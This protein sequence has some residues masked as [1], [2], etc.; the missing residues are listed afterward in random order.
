MLAE[1]SEI[2]LRSPIRGGPC[3]DL[4]EKNPFASMMLCGWPLFVDCKGP[5]SIQDLESRNNRSKWNNTGSPFLNMYIYKYILK[6]TTL[7]LS[8]IF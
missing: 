2:L 1:H 4:A 3:E 8:Y 5:K 6:K 7:F